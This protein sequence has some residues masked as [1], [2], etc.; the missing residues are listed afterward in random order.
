M[1][2]TAKREKVAK[3]KEIDVELLKRKR[4][5]LSKGSMLKK[6]SKIFVYIFLIIVFFYIFFYSPLFEIKYIE[7]NNLSYLDES[8]IYS[9]ISYLKGQNFFLSDVPAARSRIV[10]NY[11]FVEEIHTEKVFPNTI[12]VKITERQPLLL[13]NNA[14]T[15]CYLIDGNGYVLSPQDSSCSNLR[16]NY[17]AI[18]I[19]GSDIDSFEFLHGT[20]TQ[21]YPAV[22]V[23][24]IANVLQYYGYMVK[25]MQLNNQA[26]EV[27]LVDDSSLFFSLTEDLDVQLKRLIIL[28]QQIRENSMDFEI[29]DLRFQRPVL[30]E[31]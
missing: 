22:K 7:V 3:E 23:N 12:V 30:V 17:D 31:K 18:E 21:F 24:E 28:I 27:K 29:I 11:V 1:D 20:K 14:I 10:S 16:E 26:L 2:Y 5:L 8:T 19:I 6:K 9:E 25:S 13:A 4:K 15:G